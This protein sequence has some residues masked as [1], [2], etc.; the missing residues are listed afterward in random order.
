MIFNNQDIIYNIIQI[1]I[2]NKHNYENIVE[3]KNLNI[4]KN[5]YRYYLIN[6]MFNKILNFE[7]TNCCPNIKYFNNLIYC[8]TH[9]QNITKNI[10]ETLDT[11]YLDELTYINS[12]NSFAKNNNIMYIHFTEDIYSNINFNIITK[13][14]CKL[15][16]FHIIGNCCD[17]SGLIIMYKKL[18]E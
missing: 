8:N 1:L 6:K 17:G 10:I 7:I 5:M 3:C 13:K 16:N 15:Y 18:E 9:T 11:H 4:K 14:L 12:L 2:S